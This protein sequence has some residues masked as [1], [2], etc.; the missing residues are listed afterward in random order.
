MCRIVVADL[1]S[2]LASNQIGDQSRQPIDPIF[3]RAKLNADVPAS[4]LNSPAADRLSH[5]STAHD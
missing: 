5:R 3:R 4:P 2:D 1:H